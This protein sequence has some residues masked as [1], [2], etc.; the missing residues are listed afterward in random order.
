MQ[1]LGV[2]DIDLIAKRDKMEK[3]RSTVI[4]RW[5][6]NFEEEKDADTASE[7][8]VS[9]E[10]VFKAEEEA[11]KARMAQEIIDRLNA[12][13]AED[14]AL[15]QAEID[16]AKMQSAATFNATTGSHSGAYGMGEVSGEEQQVIDSIM[17]EKDD[18][19]QHLIAET[20]QEV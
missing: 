2:Y 6:V 3:L 12:E 1:K 11:E 19:L 13:A 17:A 9:E 14:E 10:D 8:A 15:K 7:E 18:A 5:N 16:A 4:K 20:A